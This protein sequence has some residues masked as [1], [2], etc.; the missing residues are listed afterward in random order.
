MRASSVQGNICR[1]LERNDCRHGASDTQRRSG[2][3]FFAPGSLRGDAESCL[4]P[5][6]F[7]VLQLAML[8]S[9]GMGL[10]V[11]GQQNADRLV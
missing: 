6:R 8:Q 1:S 3:I 11:T 4:Q 2:L 7:S 5:C 9:D 10:E